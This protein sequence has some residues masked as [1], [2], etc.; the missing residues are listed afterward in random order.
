MFQIELQEVE[1]GPK[2]FW[3]LEEEELKRVTRLQ[4]NSGIDDEDD[5]STNSATD[6][7]DQDTTHHVAVRPPGGRLRTSS[8]YFSVWK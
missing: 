1:E 8:T 3:Q 7:S 4:G 2:V 6:D 5:D